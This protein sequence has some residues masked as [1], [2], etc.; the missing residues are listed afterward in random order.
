MQEK[1]DRAIL[2]AR[3]KAKKIEEINML[4]ELQMQQVFF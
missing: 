3:L 1:T 2:E 4:K